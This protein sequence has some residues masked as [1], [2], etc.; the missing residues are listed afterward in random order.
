MFSSFEYGVPPIVAVEDSLVA[1]PQEFRAATWLFSTI[2][3][4]AVGIG[5]LFVLVF[6]VR[7]IRRGRLDPLASA[8]IRINEFREDSLALAM[9]AYLLAALALGG[10][11]QFIYGEKDDAM[12]NLLAGSGAQLVGAFM[13]LVIASKRFSGGS[14]RF[15]RGTGI[16]RARALLALVGGGLVLALTICPAVLT[17]F[18]AL[19]LRFNPDYQLPVHPTITALRGVESTFPQRLVLWTGAAVIAPVAEEFFFR[20]IL[21]TVLLNTL[22]SRWTAILLASTVFAA[23]H[24]SQPHAIPALFVLAVIMGYVYERSGSLIPPIAIHSLFNLKTLIW[25]T[26][27]SPM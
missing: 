12:R 24:F 8:P 6:L 18:V 23:I 20:G 19:V 4:I 9:V 2:D 26:F 11:F 16:Y 27:G 17:G 5:T 15:V 7:L 10:V 1:G 3:W 22:K 14:R 25:D 21:Q 13:C